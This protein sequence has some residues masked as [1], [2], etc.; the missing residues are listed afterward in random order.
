MIR[1]ATEADA[2]AI[3]AVQV[4]SWRET[5]RG[6]VPDS[7]LDT[8][9]PTPSQWLRN[10]VAGLG[11]QV[12]EDAHGI[13]GFVAFGTHRTPELAF[14]GEVHAIYLLARA[15]GRGT[16]RALMRA[17]AAGL[18]ARGHVNASLWVMTRNAAAM[19]F[20]LHLGGRPLREANFEIAGT[21]ISETAIGWDDL[22]I[23]LTA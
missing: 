21:S 17:A 2:A 20:Y 16:G 15:Q 11:V 7:H 18:Q 1:P 14:T 10:I 22:E 19:D 13:T 8:L 12:A 9:D 6:I 23:L 3:R 5:Y 4:Q